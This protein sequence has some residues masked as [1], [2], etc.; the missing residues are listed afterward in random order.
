MSAPVDITSG[1]LKAH[2]GAVVER[3]QFDGGINY[4]VTIPGRVILP[5]ATVSVEWGDDE[6]RALDHLLD[7]ITKGLR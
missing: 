7:R 3:R 5:P 2:P 6:Q 1:V 4:R